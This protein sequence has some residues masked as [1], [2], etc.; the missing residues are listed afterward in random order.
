[1][2][3]SHTRSKAFNYSEVR[4]FLL[5]HH[6]TRR[7]L[8]SGIPSCGTRKT[9]RAAHPETPTQKNLISQA[10]AETTAPAEFSTQPAASVEFS[11]CAS[12]VVPDRLG[13][14]FQSILVHIESLF[15]IQAFD[16]LSCRLGNGSRRLDAST[17]TVDS[18]VPSLRS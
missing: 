10:S 11:A 18:T 2:R 14:N 5:V 6:E 3:P 8:T 4:R 15:A 13:R 7:W 17:L 9:G 16:K 12:V 1:M